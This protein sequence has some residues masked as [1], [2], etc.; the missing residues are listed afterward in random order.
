MAQTYHHPQALPG[1]L[2]RKAGCFLQW[3][4]SLHLQPGAQRHHFGVISKAGRMEKLLLL[5]LSLVQVCRATLQLDT[6][7][8]PCPYEL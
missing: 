2:K 1:L 6:V 8:C 5:A 3:G 4:V 7:V